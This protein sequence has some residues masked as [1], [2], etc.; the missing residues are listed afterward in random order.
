[1]SIFGIQKMEFWNLIIVIFFIIEANTILHVQFS[2][3]FIA[4]MN[5]KSSGSGYE[6]HLQFF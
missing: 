6:R 2:M 5:I 4:E 3:P 1:M